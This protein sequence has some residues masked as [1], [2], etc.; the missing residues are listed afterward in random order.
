MT[1]SRTEAHT[2]SRVLL[3]DAAIATAT[4]PP[5]AVPASSIC[6]YRTAARNGSKRV[7]TH[8]RNTMNATQI[9]PSAMC[10]CLVSANAAPEPA[11]SSQ[12]PIT[13]APTHT[14]YTAE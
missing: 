3:A 10:V 9:G 8:T 1:G 4:V 12:V 5:S 11:R 2:C 13:K 14:Q 7:I 6:G